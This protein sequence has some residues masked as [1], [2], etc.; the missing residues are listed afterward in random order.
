MNKQ[1][2]KTHTQIIQIDFIPKHFLVVFGVKKQLSQNA[3]RMELARISN[4]L[5][6]SFILVFITCEFSEMV[7]ERFECFN[8]AIDQCDWYLFPHD[9]Q[10]MFLIVLANTQQSIFLQ[11]FGNIPCSRDSF[12]RVFYRYMIE[13]FLNG[14]EIIFLFL[15]AFKTIHGSYSYFMVLHQLDG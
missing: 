15:F 9:I 10:R 3:N 7:T 6:W 4:L 1:T 14:K 8:D 13:L 11:S 5:L 2:N 12:K